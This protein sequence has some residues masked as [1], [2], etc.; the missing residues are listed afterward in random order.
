MS[1]LLWGFFIGLVF[2]TCNN[3]AG[4]AS[5]ACTLV[6]MIQQP[7]LDKF[8]PRDAA[9]NFVPTFQTLGAWNYSF[10][11]FI[12][13]FVLHAVFYLLDAFSLADWQLSLYSVVGGT[14]VSSVLSIFIE[15]LVRG[16]KD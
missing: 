3:T 10:Y 14:L 5:A 12:L 7:L 4:M 9:D 16:R 13:M 11:T 6:A 15:L 1:I 8:A 2:D